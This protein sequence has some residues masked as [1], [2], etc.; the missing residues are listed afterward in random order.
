V[1]ILCA[2]IQVYILV[3]VA[4]SLMSFFPIRP[5]T[6]VASLAMILRDVTE[7]VL[8]PIRRVIGPV[9]MFD[10]SPMVVI[11]GLLIIQSAVLDC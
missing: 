1:T 3:I 2:F 7:P 6:P 4:R 5:G 8:G 9:G 10:L 11:I